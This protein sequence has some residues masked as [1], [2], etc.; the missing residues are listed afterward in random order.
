MD[1]VQLALD[2]APFEQDFVQML[3]SNIMQLWDPKVQ[4][5]GLK[6]AAPCWY[7]TQTQ[8]MNN[9]EQTRLTNSTDV[10]SWS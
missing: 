4:T 2:G 8:C 6:S 3:A 10:I 1:Q 5:H 9:V 7:W